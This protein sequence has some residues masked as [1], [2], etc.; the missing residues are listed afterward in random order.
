MMAPTVRRKGLPK[1]I[2]HEALHLGVKTERIRMDNSETV[3]VTIFISD[4]ESE[5]IMCG[6]EYGIGVYR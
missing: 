6:Y 1:I 3:F 5:R 4:S 2:G